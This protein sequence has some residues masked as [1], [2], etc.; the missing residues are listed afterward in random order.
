MTPKIYCLVG[1]IASGKSTYC[2]SAAKIGMITLNDDTLINLLHGD[3]YTL[4]EKKLKILYKSLENTIL[5]LGLC[6]GKDVV[7]DRGL[8]ISEK[9]R[10]RWIALA[11]SFDVDIEAIVLPKEHPEIHAHRR[12]MSD[13]RGHNLEYWEEVANRHYNIYKEPTIDEGFYKINYMTF[14]DITNGKLV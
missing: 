9:G 14:E 2:R 10:K 5:S 7:V 8:N 4:Y 1:M 11:H 6:L 12:F 3:D 13:S